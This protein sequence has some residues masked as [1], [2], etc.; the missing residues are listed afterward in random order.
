M[1]DSDIQHLEELFTK[2]VDLEPQKRG[3]FL[4]EAC[5]GN[6]RLRT[7]ISELLNAYDRSYDFLQAAAD[8]AQYIPEAPYQKQ[9][10]GQR[11]GQ[12]TLRRVIAAGGMGV[13]YEAIQDRPH[14]TVALKVMRGGFFR[15]DMTL[16]RFRHEVEILGRL[17]HPNIARIHEAGVHENGGWTGDAVPFFAMEWIDGLPITDYAQS[18]DLDTRERLQL[19][20][21]VCHAVQYAHQKGVI[22]RDLKPSNILVADE[23]VKGSRDQGAE[24]S[25]T[26]A[27]PLDPRT[28]GPSN[29]L[30]PQPKILDF[31][32]ARAT[33]SDLLVTTLHTDPG[34][35]IGTI[36][37][38]SPEQMLGDPNEIDTRSDVYALG[39][40]LYV[41]LTGRLPYDVERRPMPEAIRIVREEEIPTL[42][43]IDKSLRGD[44]ETIVGKALEKNKARR[45]PS[46][47]DLAADIDRCLNGQ[48]IQAHPPSAVY[49]LRKLIRRHR[50]SFALLS[51]I[52]V[53]IVAFGATAGVLAVRLNR[54]R[55]TAL[56][57]LGNE[58]HARQ[59]EAYQRQLAE[60]RSNDVRNLAMNFAFNVHDAIM[61][62]EGA[63]RAKELL[64]ATSL[65]YL[66]TL[67]S[68][69]EGD[70]DLQRDLANAYIRIAGIQGDPYRP[71]LGQTKQAL[72]N[73]QKGIDLALPLSAAHPSQIDFLQTVVLGKNLMASLLDASGK[74]SEAIEMYQSVLQLRKELSTLGMDDLFFPRLDR[75]HQ[76]FGLTLYRGGDF[77]N[78]LEHFERSVAQMEELI[79][80]YPEHQRL[81]TNLAGT[82]V[83]IATCQS[84][85][86]GPQEVFGP[87]DRARRILEEAIIAE[88]DN[89]D[90]RRDLASAYSMLGRVCVAEGDVKRGIQFIEMA[91]G[92]FQTQ[93]ENDAE[94]VN[95]YRNMSVMLHLLGEMRSSSNDLDGA[96]EHFE[97]M[98]DITTKLTSTNPESAI[99][100]RDRAMAL[101]L[102]GVVLRKLGQMD[103]AMEHYL[104]SKELFD[105]LSKEN[106]S[107]GPRRDLTVTYYGLAEF[108][109][110][111]AQRETDNPIKQRR[112]WSQTRTWFEKC[113]QVYA[114]LEHDG[115]S[116]PMDA[117]VM[118][119]ISNEIM[120]CDEAL[121]H[122]NADF[123]EQ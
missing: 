54:Q 116:L 53:L 87:A 56:K 67:T 28:L 30:S 81:P 35:L 13:V 25:R 58:E 36:P 62:L 19:M 100:K 59:N 12:Y 46:A 98:L 72:E 68:Q 63:T 85:L 1:S 83:N 17:Q 110:E 80:V 94:N 102:V 112:H 11:I 20:V 10:E 115:F 32:V 70:I 75:V 57:A 33:H 123:S 71:N 117:D 103:E 73:C 27:L 18:R 55:I 34:Q 43:T 52:L 8:A 48:A 26:A 38:M 4:D 50:V 22:H 91:L 96:L 69:N 121:S 106:S 108:H 105:E 101:N 111:L 89:Y 6:E 120:Q 114:S 65:E 88:P 31:G 49:L 39:V 15:D 9:A 122:F 45:Y 41:L 84:A 24:G 40:T 92:E 97:Q 47:S 74:A 7:R 107:P 23:G 78:A 86:A 109:K 37:Y 21:K 82:L 77:A 76:R 3:I 51:L 64:L 119:T 95:A 61:E 2:V 44:I 60:R 29:T 93:V 16:R 66:D 79:E 42:G 118:D 14:R 90:Y 104:A 113:R 99:Y 5:G